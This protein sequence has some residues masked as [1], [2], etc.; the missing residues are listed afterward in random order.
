MVSVRI[1]GSPI[2]GLAKSRETA[3]ALEPVADDIY[4]E[5]EQDPNEYFRATLRKKTFT[6]SGPRG[7][8][9]WQVGVDPTIGRRV[10]AKRGTIARALARLGF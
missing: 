2:P 4:A 1:S 10:E 5:L 7:R 9:S 6:T 8:V 3:A